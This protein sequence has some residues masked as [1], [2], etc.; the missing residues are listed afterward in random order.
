MASLGQIKAMPSA[1]PSPP[2]HA[3]PV[4]TLRAALLAWFDAHKRDLPWRG[5]PDPYAIWVSEI[6]SQQTRVDTVRDYFIRWMAR[7]P[8]IE[9]LAAATEDEVLE[10]WQGLGYYRRARFLHSGARHYVAMEHKPTTA[11]AWRELPGVGPYTAGAIA[12]I[13]FGEAAPLV[14]GNVMRVFARWFG[15]GE[16]IA[17][18][19]TQRV[20]WAI[21]SDWVMGVRP[22]DFNQALME[23]GATVCTP[24]RAR[25]HACPVADACTAR[26]E[27]TVEELPVK[28]KKQRQR[29]QTR[30]VFAVEREGRWLWAQRERD[31]LLGGL[32]EFPSV[33]L[34]GSV[35]AEAAQ[36]AWRELGGD[37]LDRWTLLSEVTH[38]F[39]HIR[40]SAYP[41]I[42]T[43]AD[44]DAPEVFPGYAEVRWCDAREAEKLAKSTLARKL[45][46]AVRQGA[47]L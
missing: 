15:I 17:L 8:S 34:D 22:G 29:P 24:K 9:D 32:W 14:D 46:R 23:L 25:C 33:A 45:M 3:A 10:A 2:P 21:A 26:R 7:F 38:I 12:S 19:S 40:L 13:A 20:F 36:R 6:M 35:D 30:V 31:G 42:A 16:D 27:G 44:Q 43:L 47:L 11:S 1:P 4:A 37:P 18:G 5:S 41:A 39:S 28:K